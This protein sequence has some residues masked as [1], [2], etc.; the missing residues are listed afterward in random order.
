MRVRK[1]IFGTPQRPRLCVY[2]SL[3]QIYAQLVDDLSGRTLTT[4]SSLTPEVRSQIKSEDTKSG[5]SKKVGLFLALKA[6]EKDVTLVVF[7]RSRYPYHGR[8]K[9]LAEGAR[10][11]GLRF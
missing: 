9:S 10:E 11:G 4:V 6:K 5:V 7:D 2:K 8:I 1:K 3:K